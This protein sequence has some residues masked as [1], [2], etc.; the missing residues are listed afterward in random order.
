MQKHFSLKAQKLGMTHVFDEQGNMVPCTILS[1]KPNFVTQIKR[2][3][4]DGYSA[5]QLGFDKIVVKDERTLEK[6]YS[7]SLLGHVK[8]SNVSLTRG[9]YE[10]P[11]FEEEI[12][13]FHEGQEIGIELFEKVLLITVKGNCKG[14][15]FQGVMK[16]YGFRGGPA[17]HG[18]GFH[19]HGG[20][21]GM[22]STPGRCLPGVKKPGRLGGGSVTTK[23][24][25]LIKIDVESKVLFV[26]GGIPGANN[27]WLT[28]S[29]ITNKG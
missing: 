23:N 24:L 27:A 5:I 3:E 7:K 15:G 29:C 4:I 2:P 6:R 26:K 28:V 22:R 9:F 14:K 13:N 19:R 12:N 20:S 1:V 18:S 16:K 17:S 25:R 11:V 8:K 10:V 21:T